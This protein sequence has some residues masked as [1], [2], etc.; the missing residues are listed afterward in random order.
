MW[1]HDGLCSCVRML[2]QLHLTAAQVCILIDPNM[3]MAESNSMAGGVAD[4]AAPTPEVDTKKLV[5]VRGKVSGGMLA[6]T[7]VARRNKK[8]VQ[9]PSL[10]ATLAPTQQHTSCLADFASIC[11]VRFCMQMQAK[12]AASRF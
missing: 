5:Q 3:T 6:A 10:L 9:S 11:T 1:L 7:P 12:P 4:S 2:M 8:C